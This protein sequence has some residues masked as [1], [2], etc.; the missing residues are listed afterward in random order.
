MK[1]PAAKIVPIKE[2][3][4]TGLQ[5]SMSRSEIVEAGCGFPFGKTYDQDEASEAARYGSAFHTLLAESIIPTTRTPAQLK[6]FRAK[7]LAHW[8]VAQFTDE[9]IAHVAASKKE[10]DEWL[11]R[12]P[13]DIDWSTS[14]EVQVERALA[15]LPG[16]AA[17]TIA[18]HDEEH[19]YHD[20]VEGELP[21][22]LDY[23]NKHPKMLLLLDHKSGEEDFSCPLE[24]PQLLALA[25]AVMRTYNRKEAVVG[26]LHA[27]RRGM[28]KV[29]AD[30]VTL[31]ELA[32]FEKRLEKGL[33]RIGDGSLKPGPHCKWCPVREMCPAQDAELLSKAGD[34]LTGLTAA[35][36]A[37][38]AD[39]LTA[40]DVSIVKAPI[41]GLT[42][43]RKLG[44]LYDVVRMGRKLAD[45]ASAE[46]KKAILADRN[47]LP[48]TPQGEYLIIR[49]FEKESIS[50]DSIVKALGK[51]AGERE[52]EKLRKA[53]A[54]K[55]FTQQQLW[56]E[57]E[58][59]R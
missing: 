12:N 11:H 47:L 37:L 51:V 9:I 2:A 21:G 40:N 19:R 49:E 22:T 59:G 25:A 57:K 3:Y 56:P 31:K 34:V 13:F 39:G 30:K 23:V 6:A 33:S 58:R 16:K 54:I 15:L 4:A 18:P 27:R 52:L 28:P 24:K 41:G 14:G 35:G 10:L 29:Y 53:G 32:P 5:P 20:L 43:E 8:G 38:S 36:G 17:R 44:H 26:V 45:R 50:K 42:L 46:I 55:K 7:A 48:I 1:K